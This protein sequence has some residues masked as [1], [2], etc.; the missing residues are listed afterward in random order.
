[1]NDVQVR[2]TLIPRCLLEILAHE[3]HI[4]NCDDGVTALEGWD[5]HDR[6]GDDVNQNQFSLQN[7]VSSEGK[8]RRLACLSMTRVFELCWSSSVRVLVSSYTATTPRP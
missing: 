5:Q 7:R 8:W 4:D 3:G 6:Q 2:Q 1:M